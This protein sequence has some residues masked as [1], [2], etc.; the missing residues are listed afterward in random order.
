MSVVKEAGYDFT[1][2]EIKK[3]DEQLSDTELDAVAGGG[4]WC[5][6]IFCFTFGK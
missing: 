5:E 3:L 6:N 1:A 2:E 4:H